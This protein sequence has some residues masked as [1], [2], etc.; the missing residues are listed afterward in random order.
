MI[1]PSAASARQQAAIRTESPIRE[2]L[3]GR[4]IRTSP[5][6]QAIRDGSVITE[7]SSGWPTSAV[8]SGTR[9]PPN[10]PLL[11]DRSPGSQVP[12]CQ[13]RCSLPVLV[14]SH[15]PSTLKPTPEDWA[16]P[17]GGRRASLQSHTRVEGCRNAG[18]RGPPG[19]GLRAMWV[20]TG[21]SPRATSVLSSSRS[22]TRQ[23]LVR[24]DPESVNVPIDGKPTHP[25]VRA[26][27]GNRRANAAGSPQSNESASAVVRPVQRVMLVAP[28]LN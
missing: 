27:P 22:R 11:L 16:S 12:T 19:S 14:T 24:R 2:L 1:S 13:N 3:A 4:P 10:S 26:G 18:G 28:G 7:R 25:V 15:L 6:P 23:G 20:D 21:C 17:P 5:I 8:R 9:R